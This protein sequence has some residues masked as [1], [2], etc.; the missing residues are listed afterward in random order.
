M[1]PVLLTLVFLDLTGSLFELSSL[2]SHGKMFEIFKSH[3][4]HFVNLIM[5]VAGGLREDVRFL[6]IQPSQ[7]LHVRNS[8]SFNYLFKRFIIMSI[9][10]SRIQ[11]IVCL[12]GIPKVDALSKS[13]PMSNVI[14]HGKVVFPSQSFYLSIVS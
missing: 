11:I 5:V 9:T 2:I 14:I 6:V 1:I 10:N 7:M 4:H 3:T 12:L 13:P 8:L